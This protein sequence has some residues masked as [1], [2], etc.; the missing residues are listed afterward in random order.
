[1]AMTPQHVIDLV[2]AFEIDPA[3]TYRMIA[4]KFRSL[5]DDERR[6]SAYI[7][8]E[9]TTFPPTAMAPSTERRR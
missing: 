7:R 9:H 4:G 1:M 5:A 8:R 2:V 3:D 6:H